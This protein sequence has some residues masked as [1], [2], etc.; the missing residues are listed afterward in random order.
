[1]FDALFV[2][3]HPDISFTRYSSFS[4]LLVKNLVTYI[5]EEATR[6]VLEL[7]Q[8]LATRAIQLQPFLWWK[9]GGE[10]FA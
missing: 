9:G 5:I 3:F 6:S 8:V 7:D 2:S 4:P 10:D 1:M